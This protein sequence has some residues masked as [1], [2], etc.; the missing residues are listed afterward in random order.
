MAKVKETMYYLNNPERHIIMLASETQLKYEGIIKEIFGVACESDLQM[1]IKFNKGF[2][3]SICHE[4]GVDENKITLSMVFRQATNEDLVE[5]MPMG[6]EDPI[7][8]Y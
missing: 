8:T 2:K 1:M 3:E 4:F 7:T 5:N 6:K